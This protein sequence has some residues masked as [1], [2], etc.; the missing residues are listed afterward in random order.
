MLEW[1]EPHNSWH[2]PKIVPGNKDNKDVELTLPGIAS[3]LI[4]KGGKDKEWITSEDVRYNVIGVLD[5]I[6]NVLFVSN[7]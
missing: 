3:I 4:P 7:I 1:S 6:Y 2:W 5:G